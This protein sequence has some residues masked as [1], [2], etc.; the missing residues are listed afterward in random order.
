[1]G[2]TGA[3]FGAVSTDGLIMR[4][5]RKATQVKAEIEGRRLMSRAKKDRT[6]KAIDAT[7]AEVDRRW[8]MVKAGEGSEEQFRAAVMMLLDPE[9]AG[10][11][12][13]PTFKF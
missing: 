4:A 5:K 1:M 9:L 6:I 3:D 13:R 12:R 8:A 7:M 11:D 10:G 2:Q